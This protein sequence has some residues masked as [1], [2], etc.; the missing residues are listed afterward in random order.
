VYPQI[1]DARANSTAALDR[2]KPR[3]VVTSAVITT[4]RRCLLLSDLVQHM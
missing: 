1:I 2:P 4:E 3:I